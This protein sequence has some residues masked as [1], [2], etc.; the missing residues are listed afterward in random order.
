M[1][2]RAASAPPFCRNGSSSSSNNS[3]SGSGNSSGN[4]S[5]PSSSPP[6][7]LPPSPPPPSPASTH[8]EPRSLAFTQMNIEAATTRR[9]QRQ[10]LMEQHRQDILLLFDGREREAHIP[11]ASS[12]ANG[13]IRTVVYV[14][15][16]DRWVTPDQAAELWADYRE[17]CRNADRGVYGAVGDV[18]VRGR[19]VSSKRA[20]EMRREE[21]NVASA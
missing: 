4:T 12:G 17:R 9:Q 8:E 7:D 14:W 18:K 2:R 16:C 6:S 5:G 13:A 3:S 11:S 20:A 1:L 19:W 10:A 15:M 21:E